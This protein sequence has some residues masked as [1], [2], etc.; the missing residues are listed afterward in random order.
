M[1]F[2][3]ISRDWSGYYCPSLW[4]S[5][6]TIQ[7]ERR[8]LENSH[9]AIWLV[10][11]LRSKDFFVFLILFSLTSPKAITMLLSREQAPMKRC[12][13]I[14]FHELKWINSCVAV[15]H[16]LWK[17]SVKSWYHQLNYLFFDKNNL[18]LLSRLKNI[19]GPFHITYDSIQEM[20]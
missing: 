17:I 6:T 16:K 12:A 11:S 3:R 18:C 7:R 10:F 4:C 9:G 15:G 14:C 19:H 1:L 13:Q 2:R 5:S 8:K 20:R